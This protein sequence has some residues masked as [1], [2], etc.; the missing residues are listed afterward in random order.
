MHFEGEGGQFHPY[1]YDYNDKGDYPKNGGYKSDTYSTELYANAAI[2]FLESDT[3]KQKPFLCYVAFTSPHDPRTPP[4]AI[5][6]RHRPSDIP[7]PPNFLPEHPFDNGD[8]RVRDELLLPHPRTESAVKEQIALYYDMVSE[9][10][11]QVGR[12]LEALDRSGLRNSTMIVFASDNGLAL[13]Q[14]GL[15]GKQSLYEHSIRVPMIFI[16]TGI[17]VNKQS[18]SFAYLSDI[19][20]TI[21]D[22]LGV[23]APPTVEAKSL[24]PIFRDPKAKVRDN[25]Y[26]IYGHWSRSLKTSDGYK[27]IAYNVK[28][29][30]YLQLFDLKKDP[31]ERENLV[32]FP[33]QQE[34]LHH[35]WQILKKEMKDAHDDLDIDKPDWGRKLGQKSYGS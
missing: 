24:M 29:N 10:D 15:L 11:A 23:E 25:I 4:A 26:N 34:R 30:E 6:N 20:P 12:I 9:M 16:G 28:G 35:M 31:W 5:R 7:L 19:A 33:D 32:D 27:L 22:W 2:K 3:A 18:Q 13:G 14:H 1:V 8:L 17:P 21:Y